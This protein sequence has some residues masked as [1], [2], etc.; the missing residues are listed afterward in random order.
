MMECPNCRKKKRTPRGER[1]KK[2]LENRIAKIQGQLNGIASMVED[3]RYCGDVLIQIAAVEK[4][5]QSLGYLIL[6]SH[7]ESCVKED[8]LSGKDGVMEE[9]MDLIKKLK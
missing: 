3:D 5:I 9:T 6:Q 1:E 2:S 7:L 4:A 8:V